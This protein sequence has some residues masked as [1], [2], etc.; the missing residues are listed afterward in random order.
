MSEDNILDWEGKQIIDGDI[1]KFEK[2]EDNAAA[3]Y[4]CKD[5]FLYKYDKEGK[6]NPN[7]L[8]NIRIGPGIALINND[9][10]RWTRVGR[11]ADV[12]ESLFN[13]NN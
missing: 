11:E 4:L 10:M 12:Y 2:L 5:S 13:R 6:I 3:Y 7:G 1:L 9:V 8:S